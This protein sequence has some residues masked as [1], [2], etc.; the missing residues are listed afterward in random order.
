MDNTSASK[1]TSDVQIVDF[2]HFTSI[3]DCQER[4]GISNTDWCESIISFTRYAGHFLKIHTTS[5]TFFIIVH[6]TLP[7]ICPTFANLPEYAKLI[8]WRREKVRRRPKYVGH[9]FTDKYPI[10]FPFCFTDYCPTIFDGWSC[11]NATEAGTTATFSCPPFKG[12]AYDP[13]CKCTM[14]LFLKE[15]P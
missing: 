8:Q 12:I 5:H 7:H 14:K 6:Q 9:F 2:P 10:N 3:E 15:K 1:N 11:I 13:E 4:C